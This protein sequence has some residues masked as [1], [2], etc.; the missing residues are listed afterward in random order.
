MKKI[1][2]IIALILFWP[3]F[4][5]AGVPHYVDLDAVSNGTG[6]YA[7]PWNAIASVNGHAFAAGDD[8][9]LKVG[10]AQTVPAGQYLLVNW[11]GTSGD[12]VTVGAYYGDGQFGLNGGAKPILDGDHVAPG[13]GSYLGLVSV[14]FGSQTDAY[15]DVRDLAILDGGYNG[16]LFQYANYITL[17]NCYIHRPYMSGAIV[18]ARCHDV[19][20]GGSAADGNIGLDCRY[21]GSGAGAGI[22]ITGVDAADTTYNVLCSYNRINK[23][24]EGIGVYKKARNV[25]VEY[26][27][28]R[29]CITTLYYQSQADDC[30]WRYNIGYRS[31][32]W[33]S[34]AEGLKVDDESYFAYG[35]IK[36]SRW[37][38]NM[39]ANVTNSVVV[40]NEKDAADYDGIRFSHNTIVDPVTNNFQW[41]VPTHQLNTSVKNNISYLLGGASHSSPDGSPTDVTWDKNNF[42]TS[43]SGNAATNAVIALPTLFKTTG[44]DSISA[45]TEDA[46]YW[47]LLS[48]SQC[49]DV[50]TYLT[51]I[52]SGSGTS[53][54]VTDPYWFG[55]GMFVAA[56]NDKDGTADWVDTI[57]S[58]NYATSTVT[59]TNSHT[60]TATG[61]LYLA[62][63]ATVAWSGAGPDIGASE[64]I[65][66]GT[67][68]TVQTGLGG[69]NISEAELNQD[70]ASG[71]YVDYT[72]ANDTWVADVVSNATIINAVI[73]GITCANG[74][75]TNGFAAHL[76]PK[77]DQA[78][79]T[80][81]SDTVLRWNM[82]G[83]ADYNP[84]T[85]EI[86]QTDFP[87]SALTSGEGVT[88][89]PDITISAVQAS[90]S[91]MSRAITYGA[92]GRNIVYGAGALISFSQ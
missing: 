71:Y 41:W 83:D 38:G 55:P 1:L 31:A 22:E 37:Y 51:T 74:A 87:A 61:Y 60:Y 20:I 49:L 21:S 65:S 86:L 48:G 79:F 64:T 24:A 2:F 10:T 35:F 50:A 91:T 62:Q 12:H 15:V 36:K 27:V 28:V 75:Q 44:W 9:Y 5:F 23:S 46:G 59:M 58:V 84:E 67:G 53:M 43:V 82:E 6:S 70:G 52:S 68:G 89:S 40:G 78:D 8:V 76:A 13:T 26:N 16:V 29:D 7:S 14:V 72:V 18:V 63:S 34:T 54:V 45:D 88:A 39:I 73:A 32:S 56:D 69:G 25:T 57:V 85:G 4:V 30:D 77:M 80:R 33:P 3:V 81:V 17:K 66:A 11:A 92:G 19:V 47:G 42:S 90:T